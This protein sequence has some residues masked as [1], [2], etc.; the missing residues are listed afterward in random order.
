[1]ADS[2]GRRP[3][4]VETRCM[5]CGDVLAVV[6]PS[7]ESEV[8]CR[9]PRCRRNGTTTPIRPH[10]Y[11]R[12]PEGMDGKYGSRVLEAIQSSR[13]PMSA[14]EQYL[15]PLYRYRQINGLI[16]IGPA[17]LDRACKKKDDPENP[18]DNPNPLGLKE[19]WI[20]D[21]EV[22]PDIDKCICSEI[23]RA[24]E[25]ATR[26][27]LALILPEIAGRKTSLIN[28]QKLWGV[29]HD[30]FIGGTVRQDVFWLPS[31]I[32][33]LNH[34][35]AN[36]PAVTEPQW[37]LIYEHPLWTTGKNW[38]NQQRAAAER[39]MAIA[40]AALDAF[41]L[42]VVLAAKGIQLRPNSWSRTSTIAGG[43]PLRVVSRDGS[44]GVS[45]DWGPEDAYGF[46]AAS[47]RGVPTLGS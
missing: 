13:I 46:L 32:A 36:E 38:T 33:Q 37:V 34:D 25:W 35:W 8:P 42:N 10:G 7:G 40:T 17:E 2:R 4:E 29:P 11:I 5:S 14:I 6:G 19:G 20:T 9:R 15:D 44:V 27:V 23:W 26:A 47:V 30:G 3:G 24:D 28:Q 45:R 22:P 12:V 43:C 41:V 39:G 18:P 16:V 31:W 1:M 21:I